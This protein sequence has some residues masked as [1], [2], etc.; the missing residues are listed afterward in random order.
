MSDRQNLVCSARHEAAH[1]VLYLHFGIGVEY[2]EL[3]LDGTGNCHATNRPQTRESV[4][5]ILAGAESDKLF[6]K[7]DPARLE[8]RENGWRNDRVEAETI[9]RDLGTSDTELASEIE[10]AS[11][12]AKE[13][14]KDH[15][16][17][18]EFLAGKLLEHLN[19]N[20]EEG[21]D[22]SVRLNEQ[23]IR[24]LYDKAVAP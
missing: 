11:A 24:I 14:V 1:A 5:A 21:G 2:I 4:L 17:R 10:A 23:I 8:A 22:T 15:S 9:L 18:I 16:S 6:F 7:S 20:Y 19:R 13:L 3:T 12:D